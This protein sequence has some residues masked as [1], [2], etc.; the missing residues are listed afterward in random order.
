M[1]Y[2]FYR[3]LPWYVV[4]V[5]TTQQLVELL[6]NKTWSVCL[7]F[8][9]VNYPRYL[10]LND[11]LSSG[12]YRSQHYLVVKTTENPGEYRTVETL[13]FKRGRE[14][15]ALEVIEE[16]VTGRRERRRNACYKPLPPM[17]VEESRALPSQLLVSRS[18]TPSQAAP[19]S[20]SHPLLRGPRPLFHPDRTW[21]LT[22]AETPEELARVLTDRV[23]HPNTAFCLKAHPH[24]IFLNDSASVLEAP[25]YAIVVSN[26]RAENHVV[27]DSMTLRSCPEHEVLGAI[28]EILERARDEPA[29]QR[30]DASMKLKI[31]RSDFSSFAFRQS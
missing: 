28:R 18:H 30:P 6:M 15:Q 17:R 20:S 23:W 24:C 31:R 21:Y 9:V 11:G 13:F 22:L 4:D 29:S 10:F 2:S 7:A 19:S 1:R 5:G 27:I 16:I 3:Q 25:C 8:R 26:G 12:T 14:Q